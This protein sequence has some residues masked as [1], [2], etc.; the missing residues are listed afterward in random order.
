M[1]MEE[2]LKI[3]YMNCDFCTAKNHCAACGGELAESLARKPGI[4]SAEVNIPDHTRRVRHSLD[5]DALEDL[6]DGMGVL[7]G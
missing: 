1:N 2:T 6:L 4:E 7:I 3:S 5:A